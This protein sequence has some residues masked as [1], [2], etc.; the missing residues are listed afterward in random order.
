MP[1]LLLQPVVENCIEHGFSN[2]PS[3]GMIVISAVLEGDRIRFTVSDNGAGMTT[4]EM[5]QV[6]ANLSKADI[7]DADIGIRNIHQRI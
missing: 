6:T 1:K 2:N 5:A 7:D 3:D 4:E